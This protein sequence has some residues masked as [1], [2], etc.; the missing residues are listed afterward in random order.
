MITF[1]DRVA[2]VT[3]AGRGIGAVIA[4]KFAMA[5]AYVVCVDL[6]DDETQQ[7]VEDIRSAGGNAGA[8]RVNIAHKPEVETL[9]QNSFSSFSD[10]TFSDL[11]NSIT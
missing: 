8:A 7:V 5:G 9:I 2:I 11:D 6:L 1:T 3:G 4:K 10:S